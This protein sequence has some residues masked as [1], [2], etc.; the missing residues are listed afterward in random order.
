MEK[1]ERRGRK[2]AG[3]VLRWIFVSLVAVFAIIFVLNYLGVR[4]PWSPKR[5]GL[6]V[7]FIDVGQGDAALI[8]TEKTAIAVDVGPTESGEKTADRIFALAGKLD[9]VV[10]TH[11]HEDH[12]G[13]L[14]E[15][16]ETV[17][18]DR[19]V[20][21]ADASDGSYFTRALDVIEE[22]EIPVTEAKAGDVIEI[23]DIT[24]EIIAPISYSE[25]D[26]NSNS[27]VLRASAEG[28]S[29]LITGDATVDEEAQVLEKHGDLKADILKV[30]HHGSSTSTSEE[31]LRAVSPSIAV[32][33]CGEGNAYGHPHYST[34]TRL[35]E[36]GAEVWRT[37]K[38]GT[39]T[40]YVENGKIKVKTQ[41]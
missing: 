2:R 36:A 4:F 13:A 8:M 22:K 18:T 41:N 9:C 1:T 6:S 35:R 15:V 31:F 29:V 21:N 37:D 30:G 33:S 23:G 34:L 3:A 11:P 7:T 12:M 17:P 14:S 16:L 39:V 28:V 25:E 20:M 5:E 40:V 32:I 19:V 27:V 10:I 24:L 26:K 38:S